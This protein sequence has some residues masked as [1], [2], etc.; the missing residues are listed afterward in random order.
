MIKFT[1]RGICMEFDD[2]LRNNGIK[3]GDLVNVDYTVLRRWNSDSIC[4]DLRGPSE[5]NF[6]VGKNS[7]GWFLLTKESSISKEKD[8]I[9]IKLSEKDC[10]V[11]SCKNSTYLLFLRSSQ[12]SDSVTELHILSKIMNR[13][14]TIGE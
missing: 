7:D 9:E 12:N 4:L 2:F 10:K 6:K 3:D 5:T 1:A 8:F 14:K 11:A 13:T